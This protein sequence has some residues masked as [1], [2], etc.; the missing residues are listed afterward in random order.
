MNQLR[1]YTP[2]EIDAVIKSSVIGQDKALQAVSTAISAHIS[3][4]IFNKNNFYSQKRIQK[5]N[6]LIIG[7]TGT[8]KTESIRAAIRGLQ[9]PFPIAVIAVNT[10]SNVGYKGRSVD[11]ILE[12]LI[13]DALRI[14]AQSPYTYIPES[15]YIVKDGKKRPKEEAMDKSTIE[16]CEQGIIILDE[17]DKI[18]S[19]ER[20]DYDG[21]YKRGMQYELLKVVEGGKGFGELS[22]SQKIDTSNILFIGAG[23]FTDLLKPPPPERAAIGFGSAPAATRASPKLNPERVPGTAELAAYGLVEELLGRFPLRCRFR[24]L[25]VKTLYR[26][27]TESNVSPLIDFTRLFGETGN[28]LKFDKDALKAIAK[29]A[30]EVQTGARGLRTIMGSVLYPILYDIDGTVKNSVITIT[31]GVVNGTTPP[32]IKEKPEPAPPP[33]VGWMYVSQQKE[34]PKKNKASPK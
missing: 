2:R 3:R 6:L 14:M 24:D 26:I 11:T 9:L 20:N 32:K 25:S 15:E 7:N 19:D 33:D 17:L 30:A 23:A 8:G 13:K 1:H 28:E 4:L 10:L 22:I 34:F 18:R 21:V 29:Q 16:L 5:D 27:M 31:K 12:D